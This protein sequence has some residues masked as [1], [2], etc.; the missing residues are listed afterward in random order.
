MRF[1]QGAHVQECVQA[2]KKQGGGLALNEH[3]DI[4]DVSL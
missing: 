1:P 4:I 3:I 2:S